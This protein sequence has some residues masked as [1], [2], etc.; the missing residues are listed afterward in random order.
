MIF[1]EGA[2]VEGGCGEFFFGGTG[3]KGGVELTD[4]DLGRFAI[5]EAEVSLAIDIA[6][7]NTFLT[8]G[9]EKGE[10]RVDGFSSGFRVR[11][12]VIEDLYGPLLDQKFHVVKF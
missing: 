9:G 1:K 4:V 3:G 10:D 2:E 11:G 8:A 6:I 5:K 12:K 7:A